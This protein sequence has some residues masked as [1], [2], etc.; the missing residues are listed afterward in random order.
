MK[1]TSNMKR[2]KKQVIILPSK[3]NIGQVEKCQ[4]AVFIHLYYLD[5]LKIYLDYIDKIPDWIDIYF[6]YSDKVTKDAIINN[7]NKKK[8][9]IYF[10]EKKNR[11][12]DISALLVSFRKEILKY[13]VICFMHDK[14]EKMLFF[15]DEIKQWTYNLWENMLGSTNYI[16]NVLYTLQKNKELGLLAPPATLGK[17]ITHAYKNQWWKNYDNTVRLAERLNLKADIDLDNS[18]VTLGTVFWAKTDALKKLFEKE[19]RYE[20]FEEEPLPDDGTLSHAVERIFAYV[21]Q[22][23][24]YSTGVVLTNTFASEYIE[25]V[26]DALGISMR[27]LDEKLGIDYIFEIEKYHLEQKRVRDF[28]TGKKSVYIYGAGKYGISCLKLLN[29]MTLRP[30]GFIVTRKDKEQGYLMNFRIFDINET[31]F[32]EEDGVIIAV[33]CQYR[34]EILK[35]LKSKRNLSKENVMI[36]SKV[37]LMGETHNE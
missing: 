13:E 35:L 11:G 23:A 15:K 28:F 22:D 8:K 30:A 19:W 32:E 24:G 3:I 6:T 31:E 34:E 29:D 4:A 20:D 16:T 26:L 36:F 33:N 10:I 17:R 5:S 12:R 27:L 14:K 18:P 21:C 9:N 1:N 2:N 37:E 25:N 7:I